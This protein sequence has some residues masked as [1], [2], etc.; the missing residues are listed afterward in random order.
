MMIVMYV[1]IVAE[2]ESQSEVKTGE[3]LPVDMKLCNLGNES[4]DSKTSKEV[5]KKYKKITVFFIF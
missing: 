5:C 4:N 3:D 1:L 2:N